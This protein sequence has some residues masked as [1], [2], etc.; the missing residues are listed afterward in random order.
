MQNLANA[1]LDY[2]LFLDRVEENELDSER[3][4]K[5]LELFDQIENKFSEGKSR[6]YKK[7]RNADYRNKS[8]CMRMDTSLTSPWNLTKSVFLLT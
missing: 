3:A 6:N 5:M 4:V 7:P 1:V 2:Y 8:K